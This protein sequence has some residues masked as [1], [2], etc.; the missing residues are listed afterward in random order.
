MNWTVLENGDS[1]FIL[2]VASPW[3]LVD[4]PPR[5]SGASGT[6]PLSLSNG[7]WCLSLMVKGLLRNAGPESLPEHKDDLG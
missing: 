4:Q 5:A 3:S 7:Y 6:W 1:S 2:Q